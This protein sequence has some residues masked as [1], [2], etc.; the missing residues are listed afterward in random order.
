M[1]QDTGGAT[2]LRPDEAHRASASGPGS[3]GLPRDLVRQAMPRL[4]VMALLYAAIFF[5]ADFF[6]A[7]IFEFNRAVLFS[8]AVRWL[9]GAISISVAL[10]VAAVVGNP[11]LSPRGAAAV[12]IVFEIVSSYGIAAAELLQPQ[13]LDFRYA[14]WIGLSWVAVWTLLFT[15][16]VPSSPRRSVLA[17]LAASSGVPVM[18]AVSFRAFPPPEVPNSTQFFFVFVFPYLLVV[19]MA[20]V[21]ARVLFAL[22]NEVRK[23][24]ELGS[25][26]LLERLGQGG[27]GEVWRARH[28]LLARP[29]AIKLIRPS[30]APSMVGSEAAKRFEREAQAIA[31]LRSPHTVN[32]FDFGIADDGTFY[33]VMELL[34]GLDAERIVNKFGPMPAGRV[35]HV[36]RQ[37]CHSLS[38]A[39]SISLVHR[40][41]KPANIVLCRY[42]EDYD[43]VKVLDFGIVK[44]IHEP[45]IAE[46]A[47]TLTALTAEH[48]VQGTPAFIAPEQVLGGFPVDNRAD[49]YGAGCLTYWLLTGQR[50]FAGDTPMKLLIQH[51]QAM[52]EPP[53]AR[54]E[55]PIPKELDAIVLACLA[56]NPADRPQTAR[57]LARRLEAVPVTGE[58]TPEL[59]RTWWETH[60]PSVSR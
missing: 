46:A 19:V 13:S 3:E 21:G 2:L 51:A 5:L 28:R 54:T 7:L 43:F 59:A 23:A 11:R 33:Y 10:F 53:S 14:N 9:P 24:R 17:A 35:I 12:A 49:I 1:N 6:P 15:I 25:Y 34:E 41:I 32:L 40:D 4:R 44:A 20:Y 58:W 48:V 37:V 45:G 39:E 22:G 38:E 57:E 36:I 16:V 47:L 52:P 29:A 8:G 56:K 18:A 60:Q 30:A 26:R 27:M 42:G 50:V 55:L 31:S